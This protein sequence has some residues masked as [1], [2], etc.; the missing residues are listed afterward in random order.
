MDR[1]ELIDPRR[2][3]WQVEVPSGRRERTRG[4]R[5]RAQLPPD[6]AMLFL[7]C[8]SVHSFGMA[9]PLTVAGL[10]RRYRVV[11]LVRLPPGRVLWPRPGVRHVLECPPD[12]DLRVGD[13]LEPL[14]PRG[15]GYT[16]SAAP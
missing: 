1:L 11:A 12:A 4:L 3:R 10:D 14:A 15:R 9:F 5:G 7:R 16:L 8:R 13:R 6:R 2:C